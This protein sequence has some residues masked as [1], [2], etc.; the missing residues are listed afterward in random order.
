MDHLTKMFENQVLIN[1]HQER[2]IL[3]RVLMFL[4]VNFLFFFMYFFKLNYLN[5]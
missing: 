4:P 5:D 3:V 1:Q 2:E